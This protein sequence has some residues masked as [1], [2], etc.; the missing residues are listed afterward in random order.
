MRRR[1]TTADYYRY[2]RDPGPSSFHPIP[3][4]PTPFS[5]GITFRRCESLSVISRA[6]VS[7]DAIGDTSISTQKKNKIKRSIE[8]CPALGTVKKID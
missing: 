4:R 3:Y 7:T 8:P 6:I 2:Y 1:V 5:V